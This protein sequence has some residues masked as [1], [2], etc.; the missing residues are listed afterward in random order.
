LTGAALPLLL[1][2][3]AMVDVGLVEDDKVDYGGVVCCVG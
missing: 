2:F 3:F 1:V